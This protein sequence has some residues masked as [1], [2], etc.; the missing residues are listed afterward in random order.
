MYDPSTPSTEVVTV[1]FED[2]HVRATLANMGIRR[3]LWPVAQKTARGFR[4]HVQEVQSQP[5][6]S[7]TPHSIAS[8]Q[9]PTPLAARHTTNTHSF[10]Q[11]L[12]A[13]PDSA[14]H[15]L[16]AACSSVET[17]GSTT[18]VGTASTS[19]SSAWD[20]LSSGNARSKG[21]HVHGMAPRPT[22]GRLVAAYEMYLDAWSF[23]TACKDAA[24]DGSHVLA[25]AAQQYG[26]AVLLLL[27][28]MAMAAGCATCVGCRLSFSHLP[29]VVS[30]VQ[31]LMRSVLL[32]ILSQLRRLLLW[33]TA[34]LDA[35]ASE[36]PISAD[37]GK[38]TLNK[39]LASH[40]IRRSIDML[41]VGMLET[42]GG[43]GGRGRQDCDS[44][45]EEDVGS[46]G[47]QSGAEAGSNSGRRGGKKSVK[48]VRFLLGK[49]LQGLGLGAARFLRSQLK[50]T[51]DQ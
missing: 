16:A 44:A 24:L 50:S 20:F 17:L 36:S 39:R 6:L 43:T 8:S 48:R 29:M 26:H 11:T 33:A 30:R 32:L 1:Y 42:F 41:R 22:A 31:G 19:G 47:G 9:P 3:G 28:S 35:L 45:F 15:S 38:L 12:H 27:V 10:A 21:L 51:S 13:L 40:P 46:I 49:A 25:Q 5:R 37:R 7:T 34:L 23:S 18:A 4:V 2:P 14:G